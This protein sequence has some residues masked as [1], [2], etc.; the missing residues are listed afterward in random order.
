MQHAPTQIMTGKASKPPGPATNPA[1]GPAPP[2]APFAMPMATLAATLPVYPYPYIA[3]VIPGR[4][5]LRTAPAIRARW[6]PRNRPAGFN[7]SRRLS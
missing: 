5:I 3:W 6:S 1:G 2:A 7:L 4:V